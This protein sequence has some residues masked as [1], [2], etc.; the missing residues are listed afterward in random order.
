MIE[1]VWAMYFSATDTTKTTVCR[2]ADKLTEV[3]ACEKGECDFT[4]PE[5]REKVYSFSEHD[6]VVFG[7]PVYAGRVPNVLLPFLRTVCGNNALAIP[8]VLFG[9]RNFDDALAELR[10]ILSEDGFVCTAAAAFV[11]EHAFS[12][13]LAKGRPD[14]DD[15]AFADQFALKL[16]AMVCNGTAKNRIE[17][18]GES[19]QSEYFKPKG[20]DGNPIDIRRVKS[21]VN[22]NCDNCGICAEVCPMGSISRAD[23]REYTG[24]CIKCGACV[25]KCPQKARYYTDKNF[26]FH[27]EDLE[28]RLTERGECSVWL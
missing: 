23:V 19:P 15:L 4:Y 28:N 22:E 7:T 6:L 21:Y 5:A 3:F 2:I 11:G 20:P 1:K 17:V 27:R 12:D 14:E 13:V 9:N 18:P 16:A 26:L 24:I 8:V 25:K 10:D